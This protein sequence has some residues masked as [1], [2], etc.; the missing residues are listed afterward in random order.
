MAVSFTQDND[1]IIPTEDGQTYLGGA[2]NDTYI[3]SEESIIV[4]NS[5]IV[6][7]DTEGADRIQLVDGLTIASSNVVTNAAGTSALQLTL[8][9][10]AVVQILGADKF[11]YDVG[12][13]AL[14]GTT[15][16]VQTFT[17]FVT[18]TLGTTVPAAGDDPS[19]GGE[20]EISIPEL[21]VSVAV[22]A[23][24]AAAGA[25]DAADAD[26]IFE[27]ANAT[28]TQEI[29]NF[30][31]GDILDFPAGNNPTVNNSSYTD[32][33]VDVQFALSGTVTTIQITGLDAA[34]DVQLNGV[35]DFDT[36]FGAGT[37]I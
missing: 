6:I 21:P 30:A 23:D 5:T 25:L 34:T 4:A 18:T 15:G 12:G 26:V 7:S 33:I 22:D 20:V 9:N 37:I 24:T 3:L 19:N 8:T 1:F 31:A 32:G 17:E 29:T 27:I 11:G 2:G 14:A 10:G 13:N 36:V 28:Y 35:A 16:T